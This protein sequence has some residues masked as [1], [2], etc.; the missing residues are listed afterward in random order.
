[1]T[2]DVEHRRSKLHPTAVRTAL[3]R[4]GMFLTGWELLKNEIQEGVY[5]FFVL[6]VDQTGEKKLDPRYARDVLARHQH[7]FEA[8]LLWLVEHQ[9]LSDV[10]AAQVRALRQHR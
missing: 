10:Q 3:H 5:D 4:A 6:G 7:R 1:M 9:A 8:S 2:H